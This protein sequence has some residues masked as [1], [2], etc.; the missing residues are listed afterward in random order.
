MSCLYL[1]IHFTDSFE[2]F[3]SEIACVHTVVQF[4]ASKSKIFVKILS[5]FL[6]TAEH[7]SIA[8][9][10]AMHLFNSAVKKCAPAADY[11]SSCALIDS[12][13]AAGAR[14][15]KFLCGNNECNR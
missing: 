13:I 10:C 3:S 12:L 4:L 5:F 11:F 1:K 14:H 7:R 15:M 6:E 2:V 9:L 8:I